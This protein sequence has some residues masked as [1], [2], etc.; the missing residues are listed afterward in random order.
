MSVMKRAPMGIP[1]RYLDLCEIVSALFAYA[2]LIVLTAVLPDRLSTSV[3]N[4]TIREHTEAV[5]SQRFNG[6]GKRRCKR[7]VDDPREVVRLGHAQGATAKA[8]TMPAA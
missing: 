5:V 3:S 7:G 8:R 6:R 1:R 2:S 4:S